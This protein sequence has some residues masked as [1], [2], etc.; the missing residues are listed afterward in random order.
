MM[1]KITKAQLRNLAH[2]RAHG[3]PLPRNSAAY[4]CRYKGLSEFL[5]LFE[6]GTV[7]ATSEQKPTRWNVLV[8]VVGE[9]L[10]PAGS[11]VLVEQQQLMRQTLATALAEQKP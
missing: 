6:D 9:Q 3:K 5:W 11:A 10:T 2:I 7:A 8:K 4:Y 1:A